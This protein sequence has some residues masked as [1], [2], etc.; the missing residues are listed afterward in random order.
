MD[1]SVSLANVIAP[2]GAFM[3]WRQERQLSGN[4]NSAGGLASPPLTKPYSR[5]LAR[6][7]ARAS[8][9]PVESTGSQRLV[10]VQRV[11]DEMQAANV[12]DV[13]GDISVLNKLA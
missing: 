9:P 4:G 8:A 3:R 7:W 11:R 5:E 1:N 10:A 6:A 13:G 12:P 2:I